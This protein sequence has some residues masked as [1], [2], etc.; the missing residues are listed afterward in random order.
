MRKPKRKKIKVSSNVTVTDDEKDDSLVARFH[1]DDEG[2]VIIG[3][4]LDEIIKSMNVETIIDQPIIEKYESMFATLI[5]DQGTKDLWQ[6]A[7]FDVYLY[8]LALKV[9]KGEEDE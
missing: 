9:R 4:E 8:A 1:T 7:F 3:V 6:H 5:L 2:N